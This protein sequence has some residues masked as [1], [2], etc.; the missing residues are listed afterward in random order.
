VTLQELAAEASALEE[1]EA[2]EIEEQ[3]QDSF[4]KAVPAAEQLPDRADE[5]PISEHIE[6][7]AEGQPS[8]PGVTTV[9]GGDSVPR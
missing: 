7:I 8:Q 5:N 4:D 2:S 6:G 1:S 9:E 3:L